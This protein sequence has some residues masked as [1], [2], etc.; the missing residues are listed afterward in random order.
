[1]T[2]EARPERHRPMRAD[3]RRNYDRLV[4]VAHVAFAEHGTE[5]SLED[6]A[7]QAGVGIGTLY[8]HF[9]TRDALLEAVM[10]DRFESF[11]RKATELLCWPDPAAALATYLREFTATTTS[12][13]GL[14]VSVVATLN[15]ETSQLYASCKALQGAGSKLVRRAQEAGVV[16]ADIE[17][18]EVFVLAS[19]LAWA[20]EKLPDRAEKFLGVLMDGLR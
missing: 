5:A 8:R 17:P 10:H 9:P 6:I 11:T 2:T 3:A 20:S 14:M 19:S 12:Y 7:K 13:R 15:D 16:R 4:A 1:M 18:T